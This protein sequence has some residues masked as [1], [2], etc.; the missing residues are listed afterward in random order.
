ML[1]Y[2]TILLI[3]CSGC[4]VDY[5]Y[6]EV[7]EKGHLQPGETLEFSY[8]TFQTQKEATWTT[9]KQHD[10]DT[11]EVHFQ[12][13]EESP[14]Y[15][16]YNP[17]YKTEPP[18]SYYDKTVEAGQPYEYHWI[19]ATC[20]IDIAYYTA[21]L[22]IDNVPIIPGENDEPERI[23]FILLQSGEMMPYLLKDGTLPPHL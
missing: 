4:V 18:L 17:W 2:L 20:D 22:S 13:F 12:V 3:V 21:P 9:Y 10:A 8:S 23:R 11:Y 15:G 16:L 6:G 7:I 14:T 19:T 5:D 1:K